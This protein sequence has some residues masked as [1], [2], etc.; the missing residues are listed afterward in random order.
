MPVPNKLIE[1]GEDFDKVLKKVPDRGPL[2]WD[3]IEEKH[4]IK[5]YNHTKTRREKRTRNP[6]V[7]LWLCVRYTKN[8]SFASR[9]SCISCRK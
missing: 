1:L 2:E 8:Y 3:K 7:P 5:K 6:F 4:N 9:S